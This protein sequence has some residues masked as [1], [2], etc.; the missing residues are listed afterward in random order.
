MHLIFYHFSSLHL[1]LSFSLWTNSHLTLSFPSLVSITLSSIATVVPSPITSLAVAQIDHHCL[2][3]RRYF[4]WSLLL[5]FFFVW[6]FWDFD[7]WVLMVCCS[8]AL[9][10]LT[11]TVPPPITSLT[12]PHANR[13]YLADRRYTSP[14]TT[15]LQTPSQSFFFLGLAR[16]NA[17]LVV[18]SVLC[19]VK[20]VRENIETDEWIFFLVFI[21]LLKY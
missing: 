21:Y 16:N 7:Q 5:S 12:V 10:S 18:A 6:W 8:I 13:W 3:D 1:T 11:A 17:T 4:C 15:A 14:I 20:I 9:S 19:N 2:P